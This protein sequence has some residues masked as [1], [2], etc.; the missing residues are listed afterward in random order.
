[1]SETAQDLIK[2]AFRAIGVI[3]TGETP[4]NEEMQDGLQALKFMLRSWSG[5]NLMIYFIEQDTLALTGA[6]SYT[7]G[8]G[9]D[10]DTVWPN[11]I[12]GAVVD[13]MYALSIIGD[14]Q[15]RRLS[16]VSVGSPP[17][18]L[19]YNPEY[20]LGLLHPY[21]TGGSS[22]VI[23]SL[24]ALTDP[25]TLT[26]DVEFPTGYDAAIKW[27]LA[28]DMAPEFGKEASPTVMSRA[29]STK[30]LIETKNFSNQINATR[31]DLV[32]LGRGSHG[33]YDINQG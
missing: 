21:P 25:E 13:A 23:D 33:R 24:K 5:D 32:R 20:P 30:R 22:M 2:A 27:N 4:T 7:I 1:M 19:Y 11:E 31:L 14:V 29:D 28:V 10:C 18:Y 12:K 8:D 16:T 6:T 9:G 15:Y 26:A 17:V 3:A